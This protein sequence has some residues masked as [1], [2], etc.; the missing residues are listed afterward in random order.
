LYN[1]YGPTEATI[2]SLFWHCERDDERPWVPIGRPIANSQAYILDARM[3][4]VPPGVVGEI[5][6]GG[7]GVGSGY[8]N[9][10]D[11]TAERFLPDPFGE[12]PGALLY[13]TGDLGRFHPDG[14]VEFMGRADTQVK[15]RGYR[16]ELGEIDATL[17]AHPAVR[18]AVTILREDTPGDQRLVAY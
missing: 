2:D 6:I 7:R 8:L 15:L 18:E 1:L 16:I 11:L 13:R 5:W 4:P 10:P 3:Q 12:E 17:L 9:R 14:V